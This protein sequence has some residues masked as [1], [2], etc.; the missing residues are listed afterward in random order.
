LRFFDIHE[1]VQEIVP[2][3]ALCCHVYVFEV[4]E[5]LHPFLAVLQ[6][7]GIEERLFIDAQLTTDN[8]VARLCVTRYLDAVD[9]DFRP[10]STQ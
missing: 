9:K 2:R 3:A 5:P 6:A 10:F 1:N 8:F 4:A 7:S